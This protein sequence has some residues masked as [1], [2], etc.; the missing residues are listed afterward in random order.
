MKDAV[1]KIEL[2]DLKSPACWRVGGLHIPTFQL[3]GQYCDPVLLLYTSC[4]Y[5]STFVQP[6]N[7]FRQ[8]PTCTP[9][10]HMRC[11]LQ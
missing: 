6:G 5:S 7:L 1:P 9:V 2:V 3:S 10:A 8:D 4:L 11:L